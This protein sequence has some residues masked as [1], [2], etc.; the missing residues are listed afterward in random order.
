MYGATAG[1]VVALFAGLTTGVISLGHQTQSATGNYVRYNGTVT[2][3]TYTSTVAGHV[4]NPAPAASTGTALVPQ[5]LGSGANGFCATTCTA[6][7]RSVNVTYSFTASMA[8]AIQIT[9]QV[10]ASAGSGTA[11]LYLRQ[12]VLPT[13]GTI[14]VVWDVG[15]VASP[16]TDVNVTIHQC[17]PLTCP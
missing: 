7:N 11:T 5:S 17:G 15:T 3:L 1:V 12:A 14:V 8:G 2:G 4:P 10:T 13:S 9:V 16:L 6:G